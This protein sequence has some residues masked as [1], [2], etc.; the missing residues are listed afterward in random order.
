M[1]TARGPWLATVRHDCADPG[2]ADA[3]HRVSDADSG[4]PAKFVALEP[5]GRRPEA[6]LA[7]VGCDFGALPRGGGKCRKTRL[8]CQ[9]G[10]KGRKGARRHDMHPLS[11]LS[12]L[13][14]LSGGGAPEK[15]RGLTCQRWMSRP[16]VL[17]VT[18]F[19][20]PAR[21]K[22]S[23]RV[24]VCSASSRRPSAS[25]RISSS[26]TSVFWFARIQQSARRASLCFS[27]SPICR[28]AA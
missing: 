17:V 8:P 5:Y 18:S 13:S 4:R 2:G 22:P 10:Q 23:S 12:D 3:R 25:R 6:V 20:Q 19:S 14:D 16:P 24:R 9:K 1:W 11:D 26:D 27:V 28:S 7:T 21:T 15:S